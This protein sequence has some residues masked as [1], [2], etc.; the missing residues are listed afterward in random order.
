MVMKIKGEKEDTA[1]DIPEIPKRPDTENLRKI[2]SGLRSVDS[3]VIIELIDYIE[4]MEQIKIEVEKKG[5]G[6]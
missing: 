5:E 2:Y 1:K 4:Y 3:S 6:K